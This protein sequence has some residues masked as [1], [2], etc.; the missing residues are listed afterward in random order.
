[1]WQVC[2]QTYADDFIQKLSEENNTPVGD[3]GDFL[4][5][6]QKQH[7]AIARSVISNPRILLLDQATSALD[8]TAERKVQAA[9]DSVHK[10]GTT[11]MIIH[12]ISAVQTAD[13]IIVLNHEKIVEEGTHQHL[14]A[15]KGVYTSS[16]SPRH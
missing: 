16:S 13:N 8:P 5:D 12:K 9:L 7:I 11:T 3:R 1:M 4:G 6:G 15:Q 2:T 10:P 14:L